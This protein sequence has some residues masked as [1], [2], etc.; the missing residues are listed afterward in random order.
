MTLQQFSEK[1]RDQQHALIQAKAVFLIEKEMGGLTAYLYQLF[2]FYVEVFRDKYNPT[3]VYANCFDDVH[4][5]EDYLD[6]IS[7]A[8][9]KKIIR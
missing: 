7:L 5:L 3:I 2:G 4:T 9:I 8:E 1:S 6:E